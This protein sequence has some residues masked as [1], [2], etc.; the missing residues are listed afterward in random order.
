MVMSASEV[1]VR[2]PLGFALA[3]MA[4]TP[5]ELELL[6]EPGSQW[7]QFR[8]HVTHVRPATHSLVIHIDDI[9][10]QLEALI[11]AHLAG[12]RPPANDAFVPDELL[13]LPSGN[14]IRE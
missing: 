2:C 12:D 13:D 1:E 6:D 3:A 8:G 9:P 10:A 4:G 5:V 11:D 7:L 14:V